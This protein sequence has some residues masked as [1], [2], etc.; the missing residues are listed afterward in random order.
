MFAIPTIL[1]AVVLLLPLGTVTVEWIEVTQAIQDTLNSVPLVSGRR[2]VA[3]VYLSSSS[4]ANV[5]G[6]LRVRGKTVDTTVV[7][8]DYLEVDPTM[9]ASVNQNNWR[10]RTDLSGSLNF[11]LPPCDGDVTLSLDSITDNYSSYQ[12][13]GGRRS[14]AVTFTQMPPLHVCLVGLPYRINDSTVLAPREVDYR[15]IRSWIRRTYPSAEFY[16]HQVLDDT[17]DL[18]TTQR[19]PDGD[20]AWSAVE[21]YRGI[22]HSHGAG[23]STHYYG[24]VFDDGLH[25]TRGYTMASV[26][27]SGGP[28]VGIGPAGT[29]HG[30]Y[31]WDQDSTYGDWYAGH[32]IG[33]S[34]GRMHIGV[35]PYNERADTSY[36]YGG[37]YLTDDRQSYAGF[38]VGDPVDGPEV[39]MSPIRPLIA[40]DIMSYSTNLW[41]SD[42]TYRAIMVELQHEPQAAAPSVHAPEEA[43]GKP[44]VNDSLFAVHV[45]GVIDTTNGTGAIR[46]VNHQLRAAAIGGDTTGRAALRALDAAGRV[47]EMRSIASSAADCRSGD[48]PKR[49]LFSTSLPDLPSIATI[50]VLYDG[51]VLD[52]WSAPTLSGMKD[53][54]ASINVD[55]GLI[56]VRWPGIAPP[57]GVRVRVEESRNGG[58]AWRVLHIGDEAPTIVLRRADYSGLHQVLL[59]I[60]ADSGVESMRICTITVAT[61]E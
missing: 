56:R 26:S 18:A 47:L 3:R 39:R 16:F 31:D 40:H 50:Q 12:I 7:S 36:P 4:T 59:R 29:P 52:T 55:G 49:L 22:D 13:L 41:V 6:W 21:Q 20:W 14:V 15:L 8:T 33:H 32:E 27:D 54:A 2:T 5:K 11:L 30:A 51:R 17:T 53:T 1:A 57:A 46:F 43:P 58:K 37:G 34:C 45:I 10:K 24:I 61:G 23:L 25:F 48:C 38:D 60:T 28:P 9:N 19:S 35:G 42:Y 44:M